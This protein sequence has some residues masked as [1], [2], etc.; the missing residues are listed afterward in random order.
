MYEVYSDFD[1]TF[2]KNQKTGDLNRK[3]NLDSVRQ[4]IDLLLRTQF[5]DR[6][7][8]PEIGSTFPTT[9]F[10]Q[11]DNITINLLKDTISNLL[12]TYEP[13]IILNYVNV[14]QKNELSVS[15][16][17]ITIEINYIVRNI[18]QDTFY[19]VVDRSR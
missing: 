2:R 9:M 10:K 18:G 14:Y 17:E 16:G 7:W 8:H 4:S 5:Y 15:A 11:A 6:K 3:R 19:F 1:V 13:R 12:K